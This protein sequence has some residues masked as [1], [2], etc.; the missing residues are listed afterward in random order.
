MGS[1]LED[2]E[3]PQGDIF[4]H[5]DSDSWL[6]LLLDFCACKKEEEKYDIDFSDVIKIL[7]V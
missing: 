3:H 2:V 7:R 4:D 5:M 6:F 1:T